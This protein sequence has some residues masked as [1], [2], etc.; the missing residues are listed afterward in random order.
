MVSDAPKPTGANP[1]PTQT[2]ARN[3]LSSTTEPTLADRTPQAAEGTD[4]DAPSN[5]SYTLDDSDEK[6]RRDSVDGQEPEEL[7]AAPRISGAQ[8]DIE[9]SAGATEAEVEDEN[10]VF[11]DG[12]DD[13]E[14]PLN[15]PTWKKV[16]ICALV[17]LFTFVSPLASC[18]SL[19]PPPLTAC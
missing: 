14:N 15:W 6:R 17:S 18:K 9:K 10:I 11:W 19:L 8:G 16:T 12:P 4:T 7:E 5:T 2:P 3:S 1:S 13:P